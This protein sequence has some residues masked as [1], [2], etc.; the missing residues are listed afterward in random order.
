VKNYLKK[1]VKFIVY[2]QA[3]WEYCARAGGVFDYSW[4]SKPEDFKKN[5][6]VLDKSA[7]ETMT[8][9]NTAFAVNDGFVVSAPVGSFPANRF[10]LFDMDGNVREWVSDYFADGASLKE[11]EV[12]PKGPSSGQKRCVRGASFKTGIKNSG[13]INRQGLYDDGKAEDVGFRIVLELED[14]KE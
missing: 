4:G 11:G 2:Q 13:L 7:P 9:N 8:S 1:K 3:E 14:K 10:K 12:D 5:A 6:N